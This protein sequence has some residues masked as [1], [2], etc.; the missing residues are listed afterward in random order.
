ME[1]RVSPNAHVYTEGTMAKSPF[2]S[3]TLA[4]NVLALVVAVAGPVLFGQGYTDEVPADLAVFIP[5]LI[6]GVNMVL[7]YFFTNTSLRG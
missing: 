5:A 2:L 6:A 1:G 7:R 3:K 4:F